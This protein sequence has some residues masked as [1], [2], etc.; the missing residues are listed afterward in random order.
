MSTQIHHFVLTY[1]G[2]IREFT[3]ETAAKVVAG[4]DRVPE[5]ADLMVRYL[6]VTVDDGA[7]NEI[8][9]QTAGACIQFDGEGRLTETVAPSDQQQITRF[10]HDAV[11]QWALRDRPAVAPTFH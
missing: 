11:I 8:R 10:E 1:D 2:S 6:Q 3:A 5:F 9:I 4:A 7:E